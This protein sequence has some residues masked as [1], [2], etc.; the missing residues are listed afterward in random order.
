MHYTHYAKPFVQHKIVLA[1]QAKNNGKLENAFSFLEDAHVIAQ[2]S[3]YLHC[4]VHYLM[5]KHGLITLSL[6][7]IAGQ[8]F[9]LVGALTKTWIGLIPTGNTGGT[10]VSP[11]KPLPISANNQKIIDEIEQQ[12]R[13]RINQ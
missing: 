6:M 5:L 3:T 4:L 12:I 2:K 11:F 13:Q 8:A 9:R 1:E 7:E 10:N